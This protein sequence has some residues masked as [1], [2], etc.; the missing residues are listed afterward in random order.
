MHHGLRNGPGPLAAWPRLADRCRGDDPVSK[1]VAAMALNRRN[2]STIEALDGLAAD[3]ELFEAARPFLPCWLGGDDSRW[4]RQLAL[5][6]HGDNV[7][8]AAT[9]GAIAP[10]LKGSVKLANAGFR[11][12]VGELVEAVEAGL[13]HLSTDMHVLQE[14]RNPRS[15]LP[16]LIAIE[17]HARVPG[18]LLEACGGS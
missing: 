5:A 1:G 9:R 11:R 7:V 14:G 15:L 10:L 3:K 12:Q 4:Q 18:R 8:Y 17:R 13:K 2:W 6:R 16:D